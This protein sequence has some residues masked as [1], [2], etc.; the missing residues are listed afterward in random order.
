MKRYDAVVVGGGHNG[1]TAACY[2]ARAG[3]SVAVLERRDVLGGACVTEELFPG[4]RLHGPP[5]R[6]VGP[7]PGLVGGRAP[8]GGASPS[9]A[10]PPHSPGSLPAGPPLTVYPAGERPAGGVPR[11]SRHDAD[12][13]PRFE[14]DG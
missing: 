10:G 9:S 11:L 14:A 12:A 7:E 6:T 3:L 13:W 5:H 4:F 1:L 2:L 8:R